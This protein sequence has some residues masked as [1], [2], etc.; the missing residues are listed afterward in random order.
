MTVQRTALVIAVVVAYELT[1][2]TLMF[3]WTGPPYLPS[4]TSTWNRKPYIMF[5][6][7]IPSCVCFLVISISTT[8]LVTRLRSHQDKASWLN[9]SQDTSYATSGAAK[10]K[11]Q[12][13]QKVARFV[14]LICVIYLVCFAP[15]TKMYLVNV[16]LLSNFTTSDPYLGW[17]AHI[18][19]MFSSVFQIVSSSVNIFVYYSMGTKYRTVF[20]SIFCAGK[21]EP[22]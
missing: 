11:A 4:R 16:L 3:V 22:K 17:L 19:Y 8:F 18:L 7:S 12:K 6:Y 5:S 21:K 2:V 14:I 13:E 10:K 1:F 20:R 9:A 15:N